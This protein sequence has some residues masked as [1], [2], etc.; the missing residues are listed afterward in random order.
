M[1]CPGPLVVATARD[2]VKPK[3]SYYA[4]LIQETSEAAD[5]YWQ[6]KHGAARVVTGAEIQAWEEFREEVEDYSSIVKSGSGELLISTG[7]IV[8]LLQVAVM[9][10]RTSKSEV[11]F[12][13][14]RVPAS[15]GGV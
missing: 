5:R 14:Q 7:D 3:E 10:I 6:A 13:D 11:M 2:T 12:V 4:W 8:G 15:R 9:R 1:R